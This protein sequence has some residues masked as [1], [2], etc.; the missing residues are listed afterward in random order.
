[1]IHGN[2]ISFDHKFSSGIED[3][4][5]KTQMGHCVHLQKERHETDTAQML[6]PFLGQRFSAG[7]VHT[8]VVWCVFLAFVC[9]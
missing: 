2:L 4:K 6:L 7:N 9:L 1:M 3:Q 8:L 5:N